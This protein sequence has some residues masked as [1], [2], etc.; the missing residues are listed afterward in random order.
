MSR[1]RY[2][3]PKLRWGLHS[4]AEKRGVAKLPSSQRTRKKV[5]ILGSG[6]CGTTSLAL[7]LQKLGLDVQDERMG[8]D[9]TAGLWFIPGDSDWYPWWPWDPT[10]CY[11]DCRRSDFKFNVILHVVRD[12]R[13]VIPAMGKVFPGLIW[14]W[15]EDNDV[16]PVRRPRYSQLERCAMAW[17]RLNELAEGEADY[18]F[19]I[20]DTETPRVQNKLRELLGLPSLKKLP[21]PGI[22]AANKHTGY[23]QYEPLNWNELTAKNPRLS[24]L[25]QSKARMYGYKV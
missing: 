19:R 13:E 21:W 5:L 25:V 18:R 9:G 1:T 12:P 3:F 22:V 24:T 11:P 15:L 14:E 6:R 17:L 20:E 10:R 2:T 23:R 16:L 7:N 4:K 8:R